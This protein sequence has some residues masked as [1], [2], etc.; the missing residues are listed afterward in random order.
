M[1]NYNKIT[2][3]INGAGLSTREVAKILNVPASTYRS[4]LERENLLPN[5]IE[6]LADHFNT[7]IA[8][9]FDRE[10]KEGDN[11]SVVPTVD[12]RTHDKLNMKIE[13]LEE[14]LAS[15]D[16]II[17]QLHRENGALEEKLASMGGSSARQSAS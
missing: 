3:C 15:R 13:L 2:S 16:Q 1:L 5:D 12:L 10:E 9:F 8:Y 14:Q 7:T 17:A 11:K 4:R 6:K